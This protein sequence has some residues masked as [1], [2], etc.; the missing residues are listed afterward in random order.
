MGALISMLS[1]LHF[2]I[3]S[4]SLISPALYTT[5]RKILLTHL[6]KYI[7]PIV[8][9][10]YIIDKNIKDPNLIDLLK[11]YNSYD[12]TK[13]SAELHKLM[14]ETRLKLSKIK[15]P[16]RIFHLKMIK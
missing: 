7:I 11:N 9:N 5:N 2:K 8:K 1:S 4:L 15:T 10:N 6:L 14:I 3:K 12:F 13:Q 16:I